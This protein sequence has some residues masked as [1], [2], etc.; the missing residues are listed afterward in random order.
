LIAGAGRRNAARGS[1]VVGV[2][3]FPGGGVG[4]VLAIGMVVVERGGSP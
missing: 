2:A 4:G 1:S 3:G